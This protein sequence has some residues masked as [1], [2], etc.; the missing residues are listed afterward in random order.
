ME[1]PKAPWIVAV[2]SFDVPGNTCQES[3]VGDNAFT[4]QENKCIP[5]SEDGCYS[6][7]DAPGCSYVGDRAFH[8][9]QN[10]DVQKQTQHGTKTSKRTL[11]YEAS[12]CSSGPTWSP[13]SVCK[14]WRWVQ[15]S[16]P[17]WSIR[18]KHKKVSHAGP[19]VPVASIDFWDL[20]SYAVRGRGH[21]LT[22]QTP[23]DEAAFLRI[24]SAH[25]AGLPVGSIEEFRSESAVDRNL[26]NA[27]SSEE[28]DSVRGPSTTQPRNVIAHRNEKEAHWRGCKYRRQ[29][30]STEI[31][32]DPWK[33]LFS[34]PNICDKFSCGRS[35]HNTIKSLQKGEI[36]VDDI[37][38]I[39]VVQ[40]R[41]RFITLDHRR[42]YCFRAA[43]PR[44]TLIQ[45]KLLKTMW[46]A[47]RYIGPNAK[48]YHAVHVERENLKQAERVWY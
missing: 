19:R 42:L 28:F 41:G 22:F 29:A 44:G 7:K 48:V 37:P 9:Q 40:Q 1:L 25:A 3:C 24:A 33:V 6:L 46:L 13:N 2:E 14:A 8:V 27:G 16:L 18:P 12:G 4:R 39:T 20:D 34:K 26:R 36:E 45:V 38:K 43:L 15:Q 23:E 10:L 21:G 17:A 47:H 5:H 32:V 30:E 11:A 35:I 31:T